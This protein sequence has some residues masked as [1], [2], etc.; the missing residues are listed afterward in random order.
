MSKVDELR[1]LREARFKNATNAKNYITD[2]STDVELCGHTSINKK[3]CIRPK[4]HS[5]KNHK[6]K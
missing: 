5:E 2:D 3:T 6:Y 1:A 4:G